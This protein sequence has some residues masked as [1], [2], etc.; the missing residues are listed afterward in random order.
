MFKKFG[1][2]VLI[3]AFLV[4]AGVVAFT[5]FSDSKKSKRTFKE[6]FA[7]IDTAVVNE[8]LLYPK[9]ENH[10]EIKLLKVGDSWELQSSNLK[11]EADQNSVQG[12]INT[13]TTI[14]PQRLAATSKQ[15]WEEDQ[16]NDS[17][18]TRVKILE[19]GKTVADLMIGKF[20]FQQQTKSGTTYIRDFNEDEVYAVEGFIA[21]TFNQKASSF[22][23]KTIIRGKKEDWTRLEFQ[24]P[25]D[26]SFT[27]T[28]ET[29]SWT[30]GGMAADSAEVDRFLSTVSNLSNS[31]FDDEY[32]TD[33]K[34]PVYTLTLSGNNMQ[35][36]VVVKAFDNLGKMMLTSSL[37]PS[38][39]F[40]GENGNLTTR[41]FVSSSKFF[42]VQEKV[43][44][45]S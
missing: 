40:K 35:A 27:L 19:N 9:A 32:S 11:T 23:N 29:G 10:N 18:G 39:V 44:T 20:S 17:L 16:V 28:K 25:A 21:M 13:L 42:P 5:Q 14:K 24:Y 30:V 4:L 8:I 38:A 7:V 2:I 34:S 15:K 45:E 12:I 6:E 22:R 31:G 41:V 36:P 3:I 26:S 1:N 37:N 43:E 33:G